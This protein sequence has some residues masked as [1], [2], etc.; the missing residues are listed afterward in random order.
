MSIDS[1]TVLPAVGALLFS[2][3]TA[4]PLAVVSTSSKPVV[5]C[6]SAS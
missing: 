2:C 5:P 6:S 1:S 3:R 4:R